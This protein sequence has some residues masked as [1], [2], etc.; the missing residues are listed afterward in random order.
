MIYDEI[1]LIN[2]LGVSFGGSSII[3]EGTQ[4]LLFD[5]VSQTQWTDSGV[6]II[7]CPVPKLE[8]RL[9]VLPLKFI[10]IINGGRSFKVL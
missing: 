6:S 10:D 1:Y 4:C 8:S 7:Y 3:R 2:E 5:S 9:G